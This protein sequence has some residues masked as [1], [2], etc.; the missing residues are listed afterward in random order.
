MLAPGP[1]PT[2]ET[3]RAYGSFNGIH[4]GIA[5]T[6]VVMMMMMMMMIMVVVMVSIS[7]ASMRNMDVL[8]CSMLDDLSPLMFV[9]DRKCPNCGI[10]CKKDCLG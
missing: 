9:S 1:M 7:L 2:F 5:M 4:P 8:I 3:Q 6:I 10:L